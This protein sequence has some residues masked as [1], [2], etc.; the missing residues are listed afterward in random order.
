MGVTYR[1]GHLVQLTDN[2]KMKYIN[3]EITLAAI[4]AIFVGLAGC[5]KYSPTDKVQNQLLADVGKSCVQ[6]KSDILVGFDNT[7]IPAGSNITQ[8]D[9]CNI[10][11]NM[12]ATEQASWDKIG[13]DYLY[14]SVNLCGLAD[15]VYKVF[16][17]DKAMRMSPEELG[18]DKFTAAFLYGGIHTCYSDESKKAWKKSITDSIKFTVFSVGTIINPSTHNS[19]LAYLDHQQG[20]GVNKNGAVHSNVYAL[21][22]IDCDNVD[23]SSTAALPN[24]NLGPQL[25][26]Q[27]YYSGA[28]PD[29]YTDPNTGAIVPLFPPPAVS[30]TAP[31]VTPQPNNISPPENVHPAGNAAQPK[32]CPQSDAANIPNITGMPYEKARAVVIAT[33]WQPKVTLSAGP[34]GEVPDGLSGNGPGFWN[35]GYTEVADCSGSGAANCMFQFQDKDSNVLVIS[36]AGEESGD[37]HA[38]VNDIATNCS[39]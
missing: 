23:I 7:K 2:L 6:N 39:Q 17:R 32:N 26:D 12:V 18:E 24:T 22:V 13:D 15:Q 29:N 27:F 5:S 36:T 11:N 1:Y 21:K 9:V 35:K 8:S 33:D 30:A 34:M 28:L 14:G 31:V 10:Q 38:L 20:E 25:R 19:C 37:S 3:K 16:G 4:C